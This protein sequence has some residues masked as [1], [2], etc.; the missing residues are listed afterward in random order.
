MDTLRD[1]QLLED[2]VEKGEMPWR[3]TGTRRK[4]EKVLVPGE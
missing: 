4:V 3:P 1:R 2:M